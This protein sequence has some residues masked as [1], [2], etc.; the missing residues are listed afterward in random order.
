MHEPR[1]TSL[2]HVQFPIHVQTV[3]GFPCRPVDESLAEEIRQFRSPT[4]GETRMFY[5]IVVAPGFTPEG[6][7][8]SGLNNP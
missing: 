8:D 1:Q 5:E 3:I 7:E 4:D 6:A 2:L